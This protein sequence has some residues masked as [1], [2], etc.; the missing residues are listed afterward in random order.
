VAQYGNKPAFGQEHGGFHFGFM[1]RSG[2]SSSPAS[3]GG[4]SPNAA[5]AKM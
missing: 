5:A 4:S 1:T 3:A 2:P